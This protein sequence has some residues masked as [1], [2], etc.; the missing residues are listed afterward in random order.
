MGHFRVRIWDQCL[1]IY[2]LMHEWVRVLPGPLIYGAGVR[3]K[4]II[5]G[6]VATS[7]GMELVPSL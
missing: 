3:N 4:A 6:S 5:D 7:A 2:Y 1:Y